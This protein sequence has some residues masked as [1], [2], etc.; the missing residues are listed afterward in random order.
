[1]AQMP[2]SVEEHVP[3]GE[4][5]L[6]SSHMYRASQNKD[7]DHKDLHRA[8]EM[9][10]CLTHMRPRAHRDAVHHTHLKG[11]QAEGLLHDMA[12]LSSL[13]GHALS[14]IVIFRYGIDILGSLI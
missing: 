10:L 7:R 5:I 2:E 8:D 14:R 11:A 1:M 3:S 4:A 6:P 13:V 12:P 9:S